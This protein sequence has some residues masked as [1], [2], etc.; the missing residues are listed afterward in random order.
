MMRPAPVQPLGQQVLD[1]S[2]RRMTGD[3][4]HMLGSYTVCKLSGYMG[5]EAKATSY[6]PGKSASGSVISVQRSA[7]TGCVHI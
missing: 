2:G 4:G 6:V 3:C 1:I 5:A 7:W